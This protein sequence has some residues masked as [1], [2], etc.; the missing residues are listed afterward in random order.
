MRISGWVSDTVRLWVGGRVGEC[1]GRVAP[2]CR[3]SYVQGKPRLGAG[4]LIGS[5]SGSNL[6]KI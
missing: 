5:E 2:G 3:L 4:S 6:V 1:G